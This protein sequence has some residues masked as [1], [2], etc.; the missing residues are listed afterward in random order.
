MEGKYWASIEGTVP[1]AYK[2]PPGTTGARFYSDPWCQTEIFPIAAHLSVPID[3]AALR[4]GTLDI[5][6]E[7]IFVEFASNVNVKS[8]K[9]L[10]NPTV[11]AQM[12]SMAWVAFTQSN[13]T[14]AISYYYAD[15]YN[16]TA[17]SVINQYNLA[18]DGTVPDV[19]IN[20][21]VPAYPNINGAPHVDCTGESVTGGIA[22]ATKTYQWYA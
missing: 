4:N 15:Q 18:D 6:G 20:W 5:S 1:D 8:V 7:S 17:G 16:K 2:M 19:T 10:G 21:T 13:Y 22:D 11:S 3:V 12:S 14:G 9:L